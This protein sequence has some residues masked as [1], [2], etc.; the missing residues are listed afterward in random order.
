M[1][2]LTAS[3]SIDLAAVLQWANPPTVYTFTALSNTKISITDGFHSQSFYGTGFTY[4]LLTA[5][6]TGGTV[7][8]TDYFEAG[9][10]MYDSTNFTL[11][12]SEIRTSIF[13]VYAK[14][15]VING[16]AEND[17]LTGLSGS[18]T[19]YGGAGADHLSGD[20]GRDVL[21]GGAGNDSLYGGLNNDTLNGNEGNDLLNGGNN[22]DFLSGDE[23]NDTLAGGSLRD[24]LNGGAGDD[25]V[26]GFIGNDILIG[27]LGKD[28]LH[29]GDGVDIFQFTMV[30]DSGISTTTR[31]TINDF[32]H[33]KDKLDVSALGNE[34]YF[35]VTTHVFY[36]NTDTDS[37]AEFSLLLTGV[38]KITTTDLIL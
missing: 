7:T 3:H 32:S 25:N 33:N 34:W 22:N 20:Q 38:T 4:N 16:S 17:K 2:T 26:D 36:M 27:G 10:K 24:T 8:S 5:Q 29:G 31:D 11:P 19:L 35:D 12:A 13:M 15:D 21:N 30:D 1:A 37:E 9:I 28:Q 6:I 23:G 14:N 18:D